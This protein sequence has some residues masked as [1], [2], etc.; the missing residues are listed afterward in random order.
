MALLLD[1]FGVLKVCLA[2][3]DKNI[4]STNAKTIN[5]ITKISVTRF[6]LV[7]VDIEVSV[8]IGVGNANSFGALYKN[9]N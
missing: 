3:R 7:E 6:A 4:N 2:Y 1:L 9:V 8:G 5:P